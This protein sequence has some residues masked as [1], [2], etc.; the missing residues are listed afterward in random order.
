MDFV[1]QAKY[2]D[3]DGGDDVWYFVPYY[4]GTPLY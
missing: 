3:F 4:E 2:P 1:V